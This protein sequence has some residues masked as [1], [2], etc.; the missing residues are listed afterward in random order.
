MKDKADDPKILKKQSILE[1][2]DE[3]PVAVPNNLDST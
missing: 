1:R 3:D 2:I